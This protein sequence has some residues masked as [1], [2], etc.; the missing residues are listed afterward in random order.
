MGDS[1]TWQNADS[2]VAADPIVQ[3]EQLPAEEG[4]GGGGGGGRRTVRESEHG[5]GSLPEED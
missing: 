2:W 4:G 5:R 3:E 1:L